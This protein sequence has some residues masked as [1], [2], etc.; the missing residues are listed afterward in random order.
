M[1]QIST[2]KLKLIG[3]ASMYLIDVDVAQ[4]ITRSRQN[5]HSEMYHCLSV[6]FGG[7]LGQ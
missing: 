7:K 6:K 2:R 3:A 4:A 1:I 5:P